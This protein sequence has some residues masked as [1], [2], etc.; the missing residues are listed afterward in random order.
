MTFIPAA[1][2]SEIKGAV[3]IC[4]GGAFEYRSPAEGTP[5]AEAL[6]RY[7]YQCFVVITG[8]DRIL[9]RRPRWI[10]REE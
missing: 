10:L 6:S 7:G 5:V 3:L 2:G 4:P 1:E 8:S 9:R